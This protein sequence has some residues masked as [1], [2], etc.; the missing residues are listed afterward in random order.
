MSQAAI[1]I[2]GSLGDRAATVR[3]ALADLDRLPRTHL[4]RASRLYESEP[5][6]GVARQRFVNACAVVE[7]DLSPRDLLAALHEIEARHHR[8]RLVRWADRTLDLDLLLYDELV[9]D[10]PVC[11]LPHPEMHRRAFVLVP[12]AEIAPDWPHPLRHVAIAELISDLSNE[13]VKNVQLLD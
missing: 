11:T 8:E 2:G 9:L 5:V 12:L 7:T 4:V 10:D 6:G 1:G 13:T 3:E